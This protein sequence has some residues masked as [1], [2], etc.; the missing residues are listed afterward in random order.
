MTQE[1]RDL[2]VQARESLIAGKEKPARRT[3]RK[4][5]G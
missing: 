1:Q 3:G 2:L 4:R 5:T